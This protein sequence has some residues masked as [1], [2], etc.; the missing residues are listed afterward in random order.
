MV[1][2][3]DLFEALEALE[4]E[5]GVKAEAVI[6]SIKNAIAVAVRK[7]YNVG[8]D[9]V[10]VEIDSAEQKFRVAIV[11]DIV[12]EVED[13]TTQ[14]SLEDA[15]E[16]NKRVRVGGKLSMKLDTKQIGRI[17][18]L[19][20]KN[21]IH[22]GINDAVKAQLMEQYQNKLHEIVNARVQK[23]EPRTGNITV[24]IDKNE[25]ML[26]AS[27]QIP[28]EMLHEGDS[29]KVYVSDVINGD[30]RCSLKVTRTHKELVKRLFEME[31]PEIFEGTVE[32]KSISREAGSRT[33]IAVYSKDPNI[34][35]VGACIGQRNS[36]VASI[37]RELNGEK[38]DIIKYSENPAE[39][40]AAALA[41]SSVIRVDILS[42]EERS[43][44][45]IVPDDQLSLAIGN[46]GQNAKLA[47]RLTGYKIDIRPLSS[48]VPEDS[49]EKESSVLEETAAETQE[50][51][52]AKAE[53]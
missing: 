47:A 40:I 19:S 2:N 7:Y 23:V 32:V 48:D 33:K 49:A 53:E 34:D 14:I 27:E 38:I 51:T 13:P 6:D 9:N 44:R 31:V 15:L 20:G 10:E 24:S 50:S 21:L 46:K 52:Q 28:G 37:V 26:F 39:F 35:P 1:N 42:E 18:A 36:R 17:A 8:E 43:C 12:E 45:A 22:Q 25:A 29:V 3:H 11:K 41:P 4:R 5:R 16:K 30:R